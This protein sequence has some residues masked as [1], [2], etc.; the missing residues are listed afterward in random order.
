MSPKAITFFTILCC[1]LTAA[2]PLNQ[3]AW[4]SWGSEPES[5]GTSTYSSPLPSQSGSANGPQI[6]SGNP[7]SFPLPNGFPNPNNDTLFSISQLAHGIEPNGAAPNNLTEDDLTSFRFIA[8]NELFEVAFFTDLLFNITNNVPG[9]EYGDQQQRQVLLNALIAIQAQE[10]L[11]AD[12]ANK[13]LMA[14]NKNPIQ[15]CQYQFPTTNLT[16]AIA[17]AATFTDVTLATLPNVQFHLGI[18]NDAGVI[19]I[20]GSIIGQEGEQDGFFRNFEG[21]IPSAKP[22]LTAGAREFAFSVLNQNFVVRGSCPN[23]QEINLPIF[24]TLT[25]PP[26]LAPVDQTVQFSVV[27][28]V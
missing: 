3:G 1:G 28:S 19:P 16:A 24:Q 11:H 8:F 26:T 18:N 4:T 5:T 12:N 10:E 20:V 6:K 27:S 9:F 25:A 17:L 21:F 23:I 14:N 7:F 13:V 22:F 15:P 2:A